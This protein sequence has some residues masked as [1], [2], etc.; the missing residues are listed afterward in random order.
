[1]C[2]MAEYLRELLP[3]V[4]MN[5]KAILLV[6]GPADGC[7]MAITGESWEKGVVVFE[8]SGMDIDKDSS[9]YDCPQVWQ[10]TVYYIKKGRDNAA[11]VYQE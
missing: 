6:D 8:M 10:K 9:P 3:V 4:D 2:E 7:T 1:M 11:F 5:C